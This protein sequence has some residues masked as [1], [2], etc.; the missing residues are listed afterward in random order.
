ML[1]ND[2][3]KKAV[4]VAAL[5][6]ASLPLAGCATTPAPQKVAVVDYRVLMQHHPDRKAAEEDMMKAY[7][8]LQK[9]A[10][11]QQNDE[12]VPQEDR[13]KNLNELQQELM[14]K[15]TNLFAPIKDD[16]DKKID[17]VMKEKGYSSVFSK[18]ALIRGGDD[19]T[20]DVLRK[21]GLSDDDIKAAV[22]QGNGEA[23]K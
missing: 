17:E 6:A 2:W 19:I 7:Q 9:K 23:Q 4:A 20:S 21:E 16:V 1:K 13:M 15:E 11:D 14:T 10:S 18:D 12:S 22:Q 5:A 3:K 8:E